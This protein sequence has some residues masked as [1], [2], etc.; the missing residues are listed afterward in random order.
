M[1]LKQEFYDVSDA[2]RKQQENKLFF[3]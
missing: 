1:I 3:I 2:E